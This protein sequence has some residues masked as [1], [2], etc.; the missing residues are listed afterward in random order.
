MALN[1]FFLNGSSTEQSLIQDLINEQLK[2]YG[3]DVFY[4]PRKLINTD[5]ILNEVQSSKFDDNFIIEMYINN[6]EGYTGAGDIMT[7]FGMSLRDEVNL[8]VSK[9]R[10]EEFI[11]PIMSAI[12]DVLLVDNPADEVLVTRPREGD[13]IWFPY[14]QRLFEVKF[15][16]HEKPFYQL[17][18]T[19]VYELQCELFEY[20]NEVID[21]SIIDVDETIKDEGYTIAHLIGAS[22]RNVD[23]AAGLTNVGGPGGFIRSIDLTDDGN[24]YTSPPIVT[25]EPSPVGVSSANATAVAITTSVGDAL[26]ISEILISYT[27]YGYTTAPKITFTGGGGSGAAATAII[28]ENNAFISHVTIIDG[29]SGY[30]GPPDFITIT[31]PE[32]EG[33]IAPTFVGIRTTTDGGSISEILI[34]DAGTGG[35]VQTPIMVVADPYDFTGIGTGDYQYNEIVTGDVSGVTAR[36]RDWNINNKQLKVSIP[37]GKFLNGENIIGEDSGVKYNIRYYESYDTD[38]PYSDNDDIEN[39]GIGILDFSEDNPFGVY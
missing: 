25:I 14:G 11:A 21:T 31:N 28:G 27:G 20:E 10:F 1:P 12:Y 30:S 26:S 8:I 2:I 35:Y 19:Y 18:K 22:G 15:V 39:E 3:V 5:N 17:G 6:Y 33:N 24:G 16:E 36:V 13:L 37:T 34:R 4:L 38:Y 29:G 7:K 32:T 23:A 9:E